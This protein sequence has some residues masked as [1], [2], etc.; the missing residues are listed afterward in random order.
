LRHPLGEA[1]LESTADY[2]L[3]SSTAE[4]VV[5]ADRG[6]QVSGLVLVAPSEVERHAGGTAIE[7]GQLCRGRVRR[8]RI[9]L[10]GG[11]T[12]GVGA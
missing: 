3:G 8:R 4:Q 12:P 10:A 9:A 5:A 11:L 2:H 6:D 7:F 1:S